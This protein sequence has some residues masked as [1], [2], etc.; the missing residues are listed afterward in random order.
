MARIHQQLDMDRSS[1]SFCLIMTP[2]LGITFCSV[3]TGRI[4]QP[5]PVVVHGFFFAFWPLHRRPKW[6]LDANLFFFGDAIQSFSSHWRWSSCI[7]ANR[8]QMERQVSLRTMRITRRVPSLSAIPPSFS[9]FQHTAWV[10]NVVRLYTRYGWELGPV[11]CEMPPSSRNQHCPLPA[12]MFQ[13]CAWRVERP[14]FWSFSVMPCGHQGFF[15][16]TTYPFS[17]RPTFTEI[18]KDHHLG[19]SAWYEVL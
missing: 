1:I 12:Q 13:F 10:E 2:A 6:K 3:S 4:S 18:D 19:F 8:T 15:M 16:A 14:R 5:V 17:T 11:L 9:H 7:H